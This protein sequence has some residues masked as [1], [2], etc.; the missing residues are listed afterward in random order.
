MTDAHYQGEVGLSLYSEGRE[1][2]RGAPVCPCSVIKVH[3]KL[4]QVNL[5]KTA[6]GPETSGMNVLGTP[7]G[8]EFQLAE[9]G[10]YTCQL[11]HVTN[12]RN[13][14]YSSYEHFFLILI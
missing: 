1:D 4:Q 14:E 12:C 10:N 11:D 2:P 8:K 5:G 6:N 9:G 13:G 7:P 3:E